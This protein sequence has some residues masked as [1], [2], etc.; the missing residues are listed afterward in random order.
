MTF[1][2]ISSA[3]ERPIKKLVEGTNRLADGDL[4][5]RVAIPSR[6]MIGQLAKSFNLMAE[7]LKTSRGELLAAKARLST[8]KA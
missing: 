7:K 5:Y 3:L 2:I 1:T 4:N 6:D 8:I